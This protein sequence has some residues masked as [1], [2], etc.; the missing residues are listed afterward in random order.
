MKIL[1]AIGSG[2]AAL[3]LVATSVVPAHASYRAR[4][5]NSSSSNDGFSVCRDVDWANNRC[6][7][8]SNLGYLRPSE[9][10]HAKYGWYDVEGFYVRSGCRVQDRN[11][12]N[13]Y[14]GRGYWLSASNRDYLLYARTSNCV[15]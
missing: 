15:G 1:S 13:W 7:G 5:W 14:T 8:V 10:A 4:I 11:T 6:N 9:S 2:L 3:A 12:G